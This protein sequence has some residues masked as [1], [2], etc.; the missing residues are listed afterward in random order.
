M[1]RCDRWL[2]FALVIILGSMMGLLGFSL[3]D[4]PPVPVEQI[5]WSPTVQWI[6]VRE[7]SYRLYSRR[8]F[9]LPAAP[10]AAWLRL[11]ADHDFM[12]YVN[13][14]MVA[15]EVSTLNN[16]LGL[17]SRL[18]TGFQNINDSSRYR[19]KTG[20]N[21]MLGNSRDWKL[22]AYVDL[23]AYLSPGKNAIAVEVQ[24]G[25]QNPR[26]VVEGSVYPTANSTPIDLSTGATPWQAATIPY[27]RQGMQW[28]ELD[29]PAEDWLEAKALGTLR[30]ATYSRLSQNLFDRSLQGYWIAGTESKLGEMWLRGNWQVPRH[31]QRAS[32]RLSGD[33]EYALLING[34]LVR[35]YAAG[36]RNKLSMYDVTNFLHPGNNTL[37]V[38]L[39]RPLDPSWMPRKQNSSP[40]FWLDGWVESDG[41]ITAAIATDNSWSDVTNPT[42]G[43]DLGVGKAKPAIALRPPVPQEFNRSYEGDAY[44]LNYPNY[45]WHQILWQ[46]AGVACSF[47]LA[48]ILGTCYQVGLAI[49]PSP[50]F[51]KGIEQPF[52]PT[53]REIVVADQPMPPLLRGVGGID[54]NPDEQLPPLL[55]GVGGID[56]LSIG[57]GLLF[58]GT[59]F[60]LGIGLLKHRFA[61]TEPGLLFAQLESTPLICL[62]F[63]AVI[64]LTLLGSKIWQRSLVESRSVTEILPHYSLWFLLGLVAF[65]CWG[66]LAGTYLLSPRIALFFLGSV[67]VGIFT[68]VSKPWRWNLRERFQPIYQTFPIWGPKLA[69]VAIVGIGFALRVYKLDFTAV[70][71]DENTSWDATKGILR[72]GAPIPTSNI[73]YTRGPFYH[74]LLALW[75]RL[76]GDSAV[77]ARLLSVIWGTAILVLFFIFTRKVT[78]KTWLALIATAILA[79]D[80]SD[81]W[82]SRFIRFYQVLQFTSLLAF[83]SFFKGFVDREGKV[84]QYIFFVAVTATLLTQEVSL[85][86]LPCFVIGFIWF[87]RPFRLSED[88]HLIACSL[89]T[90]TIYAFNILFFTIKC[91]TPL[92]ALSNS[93]DSYLKFQLFNITGF[94]S[95]VFV[96]PGRMYT[97]YS[98]FF[99]LGFIYCLKRRDSKLIYL[100]S[101]VLL[102]VILPTCLVY[103]TASRYTYATHPLFILL[104]VYS[105][106]CVTESLGRKIESILQGALP[107]KKIALICISLLLISNLEIGRIFAGY[108]DA[109][110]RH[111]PQVF[112]YVRNHQQPGDIVIANL[113]ATAAVGL[114]KLDYYLPPGFTIAFD[115]VYLR[116]GR[117]IDRWAGGVSIT[118][119]DQMSHI[120]AKANRVWIQLDD[121]RRP[122]NT[123]LAQLHDYFFTLGQPVFNT[124]GV[125]LRLWQKEDGTL[126]QVPNQGKDLGVY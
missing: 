20:V 100:F 18:T 45:L 71:S 81:I 3:W 47:F 124:Y 63:V 96:G 39:A 122:R 125:Q 106:V 91:L 98:F 30:E 86:L 8:T 15:R 24:K 72:T 112:E 101:V 50:P 77:N 40:S 51:L 103:Q 19:V 107:L 5:A 57:T 28:Y 61:E 64:L 102:N 59:L 43:W 55:R 32:I 25:Q 69:L 78:G 116:D 13:G 10:E 31:H 123:D 110:A 68:V 97:I 41:A 111:N 14:R 79:I 117:L 120:L 104:S 9:Y 29:Y 35:T 95:L 4:K 121:R 34:L 94:M 99:G 60:L 82:Y 33:G 49:P 109:I 76:I 85:T 1:K 65:I 6:G 84:Y 66:L 22:T 53:P 37:A 48:W 26:V 58:P 27:I 7:P 11:S 80:P 83:W 113:P 2:T 74:Y 90:G 38:R 119:L 12:L 23:T 89:L 88:W 118:N 93:T 62:G 108:Q 105:A 87:Y 54:N 73:W 67:P 114:G 42:T 17:G 44:L 36:D 126:P 16:S 70:D 52:S 46:L 75:L 92:V 115:R 21:Y 56:N